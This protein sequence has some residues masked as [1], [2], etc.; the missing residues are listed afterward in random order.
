MKEW[1]NLLNDSKE[2]WEKNAE[3]LDDYLGDL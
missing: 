2:R 3:F 1:E